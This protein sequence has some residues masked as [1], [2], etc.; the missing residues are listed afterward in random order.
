MVHSSG[1]VKIGDFGMTRPII[2]S[3]YYRFTKKGT[4]TTVI[5][6]NQ[7]VSIKI[8]PKKILLYLHSQDIDVKYISFV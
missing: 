7:T 5:Q 8:K 4:V 1:R 2:E 6:R 3:E